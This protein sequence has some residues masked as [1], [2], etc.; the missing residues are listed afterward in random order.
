MDLFYKPMHFYIYIA[1][2]ACIDLSYTQYMHKQALT[3]L[4]PPVLYRTNCLLSF[5]SLLP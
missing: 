2:T 3:Y 4:A 5:D 1:A